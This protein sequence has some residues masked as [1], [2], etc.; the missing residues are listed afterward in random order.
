MNYHG[1]E[2][3]KSVY[4]NTG[5]TWTAP[6]CL[7]PSSYFHIFLL[8][9]YLLYNEGLENEQF[10]GI[11]KLSYGCVYKVMNKY[12]NKVI[13]YN[14]SYIFVLKINTKKCLPKCLYLTTVHTTIFLYI[15]NCGRVN[16]Y[17]A[18]LIALSS[19]LTL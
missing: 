9:E 6:I 5:I 12:D 13:K 14:T 19:V 17:M 8:C 16:R 15:S 7:Q 1:A 4:Q 10:Y 11:Q 3:F 2:I 18:F